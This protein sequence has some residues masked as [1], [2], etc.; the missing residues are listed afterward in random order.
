M[1]E[2]ATQ[3]KFNDEVDVFLT[4]EQIAQRVSE[5]AA[6][7]DAYYEQNEIKEVHALCL[8]KGSLIFTADLVRKMKTPVIIDFLQVASYDGSKSTGK[9]KFKTEPSA[10][11][12]GSH[13]LVIEDIIDTGNTL[14][15]V[16]E[17]LWEME[18]QSITLCSFLDKPARRTVKLQGDFIGFTIPDHFVVGYG[19]DYNQRYREL[20]FVGILKPEVYASE[21]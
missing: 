8:L 10:D 5:L 20:P 1:Q 15:C 19:L 18:P 12:T 6:E 16:I 4:E 13:L 3:I 11:I 14:K 21:D 7:L 9:L 17:R 2:D